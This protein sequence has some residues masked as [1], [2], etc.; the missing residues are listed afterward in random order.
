MNS[1]E[2]NWSFNGQQLTKIAQ[3][4]ALAMLVGSIPF[5][6][7][8]VRLRAAGLARDAG[9][10]LDT[11]RRAVG[12]PGMA[13]VV[14][15]NVAKGFVPVYLAKGS[16]ASIPIVALVGVV[17]VV[18]HCFSYWLMFK[19]SGNGGSVAARSAAGI[20]TCYIGG[21]R[22]LSLFSPRLL[23]I[24]PE[25]GRGLCGE[26]SRARHGKN[27]QNYLL[28]DEVKHASIESL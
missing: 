16:I 27:Q 17:A 5:G 22:C 7:I 4:I 1:T 20:A 12:L 2:W 18:S 19:R 15:L 21:S 24:L 10:S 25:R 26:R 14:A 11:I 13:F 6:H 8:A 3:M 9:V 23:D 28:T